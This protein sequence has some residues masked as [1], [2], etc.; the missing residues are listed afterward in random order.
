MSIEGCGLQRRHPG[1]GSEVLEVGQ[2]DVSRDGRRRRR[3]KVLFEGGKVGCMSDPRTG[4]A[5]ALSVC[6][7]APQV[8]IRFPQPGSDDPDRVTVTG[9]PG[10]VDNAI[11]HLLN[12][13]E[14]YMM[15]VTETE[16]MAAYMKPPSRHEVDQ[17][18]PVKGFVVRDAPWNVSGTEAPDMSSAEDFPT[19]GVGIAPK[20][21]SA[22]GP[23]KF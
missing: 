12:L 5:D 7:P 11:D 20:Q 19:F 17:R 21:T 8:D 6:P 23:K 13:E 18:G 22:W 16:T 1:C 14:E 9:L 2:H 4:P 3:K 15:N 10:K